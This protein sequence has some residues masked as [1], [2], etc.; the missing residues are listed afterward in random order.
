MS[1]GMDSHRETSAGPDPSPDPVDGLE[2][3]RNCWK[4][5]RADRA[6]VLI[7]AAPYYGALRRA[8]LS[9][10][11]RVF[12]VGWDIDSRTRL[13]GPDGR[14]DDGYPETLRDF[15]VELVRRRP[16]L[17]V[18]VLLWDYAVLY[19]LEREPLPALSLSWAVPP[20]I[21]VCLDDRIPLGSSHHQKVV[22]IDDRIAFCGGIDLTIRRWDRP[23]HRH[24]D[25]D[26]TDPAGEPYAPFHDVQML[27]DGEAARSIARL[28]RRRWSDATCSAA[29]RLQPTGDPWPAGLEPDLTD[30][31]IG[32]ART[33]PP[34]EGRPGVREVERLFADGFERVR[35]T[36]YVENQ[37]MT[38]VAM[39]RRLA[40]SLAE[41][42]GLEAV[43]VG[44]GTPASWLETQTMTAGRQRFARALRGTGCGDRVGLLHPC[45]G[46]G[47]TE[48]EVMLHSK[49]TILDDRLLHVGSANLARRSMGTDTELD[50]AV[51]A[52][53][54]E[55]RAA[56][57]RLR[58]RM[59][60]HHL[61]LD[62]DA[63]AEA[64]ERHGSMLAAIREAGTGG[65]RLRPIDDGP[66]DDGA[67]AGLLSDVADPE[68]PIAAD[69]LPHDMFGAERPEGLTRFLPRVLLLL[70]VLGVLLVLWRLTPLAD[71]IRVET[72][73]DLLDGVGSDPPAI[74]AALGGFLA[75]SLVAFPVTVL[76][77]ASAAVFG[78]WLG[79][80]VAATGSLGG[81][82]LGYGA[83][84]LLRQRWLARATGA[85]VHRIS[86]ALARRG[87]VGITAVRLMPVAPFTLI[88]LAAGA[89]HVS[90]R[91]FMAG[92]VLGMAPGL[93]AMTLLGGQLAD[94]LRDPG[95]GTVAA[96]GGLLLAWIALVFLLQRVA[97]RLDDRR[98][99]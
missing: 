32:I 6:S 22:V 43:L 71:L 27:V 17:R 25:P 26:R 69:A 85:R 45:S 18:H 63:M 82:A 2:P 14:A 53:T 88:N 64:I 10:Q 49:V 16:R 24:D 60:G 3:G 44:P 66:V 68:R 95:L 65:H 75:G 52:D 48:V 77:L 34:F 41:R 38:D 62:A 92:T 54:A 11:R 20:A 30:V 28:V 83:G 57:R 78:P 80:A 72:V 36:A 84:R 50:L 42:P 9:A 23:E 55:H 8:L 35:E 7:D 31:R 4:I 58:H 21:E 74:A 81:A 67:L 61:G 79:L 73:S 96:F 33:V 5:V 99:S 76:I 94:L 40:A 15:L 37:F 91:D 87:I 13:V 1:N 56:I 97:T 47:T 93:V 70:L 19:A 51:V 29:P 98:R 90:F 12:I 89:M 46:D 86:R 59:L 39:A